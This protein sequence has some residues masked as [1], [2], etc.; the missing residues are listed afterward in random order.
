MKTAYMQAIPDITGS[1]TTKQEITVSQLINCTFSYALELEE[2]N[3]S[4]FTQLLPNLFLQPNS[5]LKIT[6]AL[7]SPDVL[8][9][10]ID[11][12][13]FLAAFPYLLMAVI[14]QSAGVLADLA[15]TKGRL[16]TTQV[17]DNE[18]N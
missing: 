6:A 1:V 12:A 8:D 9:Y 4:E 3:G 18:H 14:V 5:N 13:G 15:R 7:F 17:C 10:R 16:T 11:K 2:V